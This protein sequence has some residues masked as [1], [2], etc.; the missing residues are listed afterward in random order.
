VA[1]VIAKV[2]SDDGA[3]ITGTAIRIDGGA[4]A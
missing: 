4:H 3:F 1:S 2:A